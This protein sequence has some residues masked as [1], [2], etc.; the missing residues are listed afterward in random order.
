MTKILV[1]QKLKWEHTQACKHREHAQDDP[2][3]FFFLFLFLRKGNRLKKGKMDTMYGYC[4]HEALVAQSWNKETIISARW[5]KD[6]GR[7]K[8]K[9][10]CQK[11]NHGCKDHSSI[12]IRLL[13]K[14]QSDTYVY[15]SALNNTKLHKQ[16]TQHTQEKRQRN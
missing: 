4:Q 12:Y 7:Q 15:I 2:K 11:S 6:W 3:S 5:I 1:V 14:T 9:S 16:H 8:Q 13:P 10:M